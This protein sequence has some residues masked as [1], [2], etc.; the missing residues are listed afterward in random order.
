MQ[1]YYLI[2]FS[3]GIFLLV[4]I[5]WLLKK[6][7]LRERYAMLWLLIAVAMPLFFWNVRFITDISHYLGIAYPPTLVFM[8]SMLG[9]LLL[10]LMLSVIVSHHSDKIIKLTQEL[11]LLKSKIK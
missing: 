11:A 4:T 3:A 6:N 1:K 7:H 10:T 5:I 9:L 8:A 2:L